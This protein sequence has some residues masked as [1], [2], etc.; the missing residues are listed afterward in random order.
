MMRSDLLVFD[1]YV[2]G[3]VLATPVYTSA[4]HNLALAAYDSLAIFAVVD[5][6][7]GSGSL[8]VNVEHS[9]DGRFWLLKNPS[10]LEINGGWN[11]FVANTPAAMWGYARGGL[12]PTLGHARLK[13]YFSAGGINGHVR[14]HVT[15]RDPRTLA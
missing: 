10:N 15:M 12:G 11:A 14:I 7:T 5:Q 6:A 4:I 3:P 1:E 2:F 9:S 13:I 8:M